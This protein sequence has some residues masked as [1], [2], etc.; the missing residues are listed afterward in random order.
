MTR[1]QHKT[2]PTWNLDD[3]YLGPDDPTI[4]SD[5]KIVEGKVKNFAKRYEG[6]MASL[7]G[8]ELGQAIAEYE[9]MSE[10]FSR[11]MS[12][13]QLLF[14]VDSE[15][16]DIAAF[17]QNMNERVTTISTVTLFFELELNRIDDDILVKQIKDPAA[18]KYLPWI[19]AT[20]IFKPYQLTDDLEKILHEKQP[21]RVCSMKAWWGCGL[22]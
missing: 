16:P 11:I 22:T 2:L 4:E 21:G 20:R 10:N 14:A 8:A 19:D 5:L 15:N 3:L 13:A 6:N 12:Y 17:Y 18:N 9:T 7:E 1:N